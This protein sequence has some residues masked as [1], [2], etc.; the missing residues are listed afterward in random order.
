MHVKNMVVKLMNDELKQ[1]DY[2]LKISSYESIK[3]TNEYSEVEADFYYK[4]VCCYNVLHEIAHVIY[5]ENNKNYVGNN[6]KKLALK[7]LNEEVL[8]NQFA[9][10]FYKCKIYNKNVGKI[11]NVNV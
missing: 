7:L 9:A 6:D 3:N 1:Y 4:F 2:I 5:G 11:Q 10:G 8:A